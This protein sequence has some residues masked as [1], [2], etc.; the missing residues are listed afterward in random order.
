[1]KSNYE[2]FANN[3]LVVPRPQDKD[4]DMDIVDNLGFD[5]SD[6]VTLSEIAMVGAWADANVLKK[7][8]QLNEGTLDVKGG[9][10][11]ENMGSTS[12]LNV[13]LLPIKFN[14]T[15]HG[16][17]GIR[18]GDTFHIAD[19]PT[20]YKNKVFQVTNVSH[21]IEQNLWSTKIEG[22]LRNLK[23]GSGVLKENSKTGT[24]AEVST[25]E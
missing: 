14:F 16:V 18:V 17:S 11:A 10:L 13:P 22:Q 2:F 20:K 15:I 7:L 4:E 5:G 21:S 24:Q 12:T 3:A 19:L 8:Q 25:E 1:M 9:K 6:T 23:I